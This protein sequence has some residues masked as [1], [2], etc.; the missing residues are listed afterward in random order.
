[1]DE[2]PEQSSLS[3][4]GDNGPEKPTSDP[5]KTDHGNTLPLYFEAFE[6]IRGGFLEVSK[7]HTSQFPRLY[8]SEILGNRKDHDHSL[9]H[10]R[11]EVSDCGS[12]AEEE[13]KLP[14]TMENQEEVKLATTVENEEEVGP[15]TTVENEEEVDLATTMENEERSIQ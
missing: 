15:A 13:V 14:T 2:E 10:P 11:I 6:I 3:D 4:Y 7:G 1:M 5:N 12:T 9:E 8:L